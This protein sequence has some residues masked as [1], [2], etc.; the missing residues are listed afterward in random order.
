MTRGL[1]TIKTAPGV[2][3]SAIKHDSDTLIVDSS[4]AYVISLHWL[5]WADETESLSLGIVSL[6]C[7]RDVGSRRCVTFRLATSKTDPRGNGASRRLSCV[8]KLPVEVSDILPE[9]CPVCA[10]YRQVSRSYSL[11]GWAIADDCSGKP[12]FPRADSSRAPKAQL[13]QTWSVVTAQSKKSSGHSPRRSRVKR[14]ARQRWSVWLIQFMGRWA[15]SL[16]SS[17]LKKPW[18][19]SQNLLGKEA[20]GLLHKEPRGEQRAQAHWINRWVPE[21]E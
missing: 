16:Y 12:L 11:F 14:Y 20:R 4:D 9:A 1:D 3:L 21:V 18:R 17:R 6:Y 5:L 19:R 2:M 7:T 8:C 10:V 15:A 13:V